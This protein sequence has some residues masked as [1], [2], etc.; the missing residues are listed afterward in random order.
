MHALYI[1]ISAQVLSDPK[2]MRALSIPG[3]DVTTL[4]RLN[5][6]F[7]PTSPFLGI[8]PN[9]V[10]DPDHFWVENS[11]LL[12]DHQLSLYQRLNL[13]MLVILEYGY[14]TTQMS[15]YELYQCIIL[16][17]RFFMSTLCCMFFVVYYH[18]AS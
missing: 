16:A 5:L 3:V 18:T 17:M 2:F 7:T 8:G 11:V 12:L 13:T 15:Y 4:T 14:I 10:V 6:K 9:S 1:L